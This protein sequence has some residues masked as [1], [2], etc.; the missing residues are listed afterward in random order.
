MPRSHVRYCVIAIVSSFVECVRC[1]QETPGTKVLFCLEVLQWF[2]VENLVED[3][4]PVERERLEYVIL[5][6]I[7]VFSY[8]RLLLS[9]MG[10]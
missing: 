10:H 7:A 3:A 2:S 1:D 8:Y 9:E 5:L 6:L 4:M